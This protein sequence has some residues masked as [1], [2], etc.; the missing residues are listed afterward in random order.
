MELLKNRDDYE[1]DLCVV[2]R[3]TDNGVSLID[4]KD[5]VFD[6]DGITKYLSEQFYPGQTLASCDAFFQRG[7]EY[8]LMEFKNRVPQ[9]IKP[10][11]LKKKVFMSFNLLRLEMDQT[12]S[13]EDA[14]DHT[15]LFVIFRD[16]APAQTAAGGEKAVGEKAAND[17]PPEPGSYLALVDKLHQLAKIKETE[18]ILFGLRELKDKFCHQIYT[19]P[20]SEFMDKWY[21]RL[22][23]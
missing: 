22:F 19:L 12:I 9:R 5:K 7:D 10:G 11:E 4:T 2:S 21:P 15:T 6:F 8:Y 16:D 3:D 13:V 23:P 18:P 1:K 20:K 14:R 17:S